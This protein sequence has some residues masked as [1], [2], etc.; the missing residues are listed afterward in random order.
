MFKL[1]NKCLFV[2]LLVGL[3]STSECRGCTVVYNSNSNSISIDRFYY[4][5][6]NYSVIYER[7]YTSIYLSNVNRNVGSSHK[8]SRRDSR[9]DCK[10]CKYCRNDSRCKG[11]TS[12]ILFSYSVLIR[13]LLLWLDWYCKYLITFCKYCKSRGD[14]RCDS[15][16]D[17]D[18]DS[19]NTS[20]SDWRRD[21]N[22]CKSCSYN[23]GVTR[24]R[25]DR[26]KNCCSL[27]FLEFQNILS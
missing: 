5:N 19:I 24:S 9:K 7:H 14:S 23:D 27:C 2:L 21:C 10:D 20:R 6:H 1:N 11:F 22:L 25:S 18:K 16:K 8:G 15:C 13:K 17:K 26:C 12:K 4:S 3:L